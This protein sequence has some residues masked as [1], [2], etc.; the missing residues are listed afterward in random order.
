MLIE[1]SFEVPAPID[2]VWNYMQDVQKVVVCMPGAQLTETIDEDNYKGKI[3]IKLGPVS[4][5]FN[6]KVSIEERDETARRIVMK[7]SG[8]EQRGKGAASATVTSSLEEVPNGTLVKVVQDLKVQGQAAQFSRGMMQDVS[9]KLTKQF[10]DC[11]KTNMAAER[12]PTAAASSAAD[13]RSGGGPASS[14][15]APAPAQQ[16]VAKPVGGIRLGLSALGSAIVRFFKKLFGG[17]NRT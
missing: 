5:S 14:A 17:R 15:G 12:Q 16:V 6:G 10:A 7:G 13:E 4:L 2:Y 11:L 8:M 9:S 3:L 1:N